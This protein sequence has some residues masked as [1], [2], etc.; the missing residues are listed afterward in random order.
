MSSAPRKG[1]FLGRIP[2][3]TGLWEVSFDGDLITSV[4]CR[5]ESFSSERCLWITP[6]LFDLQINGISGI[7]FTDP[8]LTPGLIE[9]ADAFIRSSGTS[10]VLSDH[11]HLQP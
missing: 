1:K 2:G 3:R 7:N 11:H 8:S 4:A 9:R 6:G 5:D 10:R